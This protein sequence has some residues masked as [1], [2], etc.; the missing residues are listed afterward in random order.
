MADLAVNRQARFD[1]E[2]LETYEAGIELYGFEVKSVKAGRM[3]LA[4][5][6][7]VIKDGE[8]WLTNAAIPP[9]QPKNTPPGYHLGRSRR[10]LLHRAELKELIGKSAQKGLT[11]IPLKVYTKGPRIKVAIGL[12]RHR[13]RYDQRERIRA[14]EDRRKIER[15]L[16]TGT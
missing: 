4:G 16:K 14:R 3:T 5:A 13:K 8:A 2:I 12:A 7:A 1:Y 6:F 9:Y 10:L 15:A 11:L